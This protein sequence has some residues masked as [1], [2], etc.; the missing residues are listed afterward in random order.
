HGAGEEGETGRGHETAGNQS[1]KKNCI[2]RQICYNKGSERIA[3]WSFMHR[4]S[5]AG[6]SHCFRGV[7]KMSDAF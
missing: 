4:E 5:K 1:E 7:L 6:S 3:I 2:I